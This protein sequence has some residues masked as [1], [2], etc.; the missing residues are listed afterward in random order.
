[1]TPESIVANQITKWFDE[2]KS[3]GLPLLY[4]RRQAGGFSYKKGL[5]DYY[6]SFKGRHFELETKKYEGEQSIMQQKWQKIFEDNGDM[7]FLAKDFESFQIDFTLF[8]EQNI[9]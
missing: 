1:M 5:P 9:F 8:M 7:Y 4:F 2:L 3:K 6:G